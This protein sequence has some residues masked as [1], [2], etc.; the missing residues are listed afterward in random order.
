MLD[1]SVDILYTHIMDKIKIRISSFVLLILEND[2]QVFNL[3]KKDNSPNRNGLL[4]KLIPN[5]LLFRKSRR[6]QIKSLLSEMGR[7]NAVDIYETVN[8]V[9]NQVYF[10]DTSIEDLDSEVWILPTKH[11]KAVFEEIIESE[12]RLA[13]SSISEYLRGL[14]NEYALLPQYKREEIAFINELSLLQNACARGKIV[15]FTYKDEKFN[16]FP[17]QHMFGFLYDQTNSIIGYDVDRK[18]I[19]SFHITDIDNLYMTST[20]YVPSEKLI[21]AL[22]EYLDSFVYDEDNIIN[23]GDDNEN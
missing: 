9:L 4:N 21:N 1:F 16:F 12:T 2:A 17:F 7:G 18:Q 3:I 14:L 8:Q 10:N 13:A 23:F 19:R 11:T 6:E 20:K 22:Q 15:H 5:L